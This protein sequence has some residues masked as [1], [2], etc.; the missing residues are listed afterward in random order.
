MLGLLLKHL[1]RSST[2]AVT[3]HASMYL[4]QIPTL[5]PFLRLVHHFRQNYHRSRSPRGLVKYWE[6]H[7]ALY[8]MVI[9]L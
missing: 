5:F 4:H 9:H 2:Y 6:H 3:R 1:R 7:D 8:F